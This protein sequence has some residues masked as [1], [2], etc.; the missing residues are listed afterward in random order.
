MTETDRQM[1]SGMSVRSA[2]ADNRYVALMLST[3]ESGSQ[4][5]ILDVE[6]AGPLLKASRLVPQP[7][8]NERLSVP[9]FAGGQL[10]AGASAWDPGGPDAS[11]RLV[12][13]DLTNLTLGK[14]TIDLPATWTSIRLSPNGK[15]LVWTEREEAGIIFIA[16]IGSTGKRRLANASDVTQIGW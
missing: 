13:I 6:T 2:S 9:H 8:A 14:P 11:R 3:P 16:A 15:D 4:V 1:Y 12:T 5:A 10:Y 7:A